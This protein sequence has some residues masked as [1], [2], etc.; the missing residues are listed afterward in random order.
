MTPK[1]CSDCLAPIA[2]GHKKCGNCRDRDEMYRERAIR[3]AQDIPVC[4]E[5][6]CE[7]EPA[8]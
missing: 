2:G 6:L 8:V 5:G 4:L 1:I 7:E 3:E